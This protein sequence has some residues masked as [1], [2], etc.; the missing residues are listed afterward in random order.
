M[1]RSYLTATQHVLNIRKPFWLRFLEKIG[2]SAGLAGYTA[3][4][5]HAFSSVYTT[6]RPF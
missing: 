5:A 3:I 6:P 4:A 2:V 1:V